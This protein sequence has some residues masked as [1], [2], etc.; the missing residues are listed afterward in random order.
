MPIR[1][2]RSIVCYWHDGAFVV[3]NF[4]TRITVSLDPVAAELLNELGDWTEPEKVAARF[5]D[6]DPESVRQSLADLEESGL[7]VRQGQSAA[8]H[9][10]VVG[11]SW[12][13]WNMS[14]RYL[15]TMTKNA[16]YT[17]DTPELREEL[18][19]QGGRPALFKSYPD[20]DVVLLPRIPRPIGASFEEVLY[21]RRTHRAFAD[22]DVPLVDFATLLSSVFGPAQFIDADAYGSLMQRT[23]AS[24]GARQEIEAYVLVRRVEALAPG[25][26]HYNGLI[27]GL[28]F[29]GDCP[30]WQ[31]VAQLSVNQRGIEDAAFAIVL[32]SLVERMR[33]KYRTAR[34]YRIML[35]DA[36]H[37]AQTFAMVTTALGLGPFQTAAFADTDVEDLLGIDGVDE[38]ALYLLS[39]GVPA[40]PQ[41]DGTN[42]LKTPAGLAAFRRSRI[43]H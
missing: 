30:P 35:M 24:G 3:E 38:T 32:T 4:R 29:L 25:I 21:R 9:D 17:E 8:E 6:F 33:S 16:P 1:R 11:T 18:A 7:I 43:A 34:T 39:A 37:L 20:A 15:H 26:Y 36:G 2:A 22:E 41:Q 27:H 5:P 12:P 19:A 31:D 28:E 42:G 14:A 40:D 10:E 13:E 23:S